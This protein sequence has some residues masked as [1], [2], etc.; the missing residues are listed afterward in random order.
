VNSVDSG[1]NLAEVVWCDHVS[2]HGQWFSDQKVPAVSIYQ[3]RGKKIWLVVEG[4]KVKV[5]CETCFMIA[6]QRPLPT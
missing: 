4:G 3:P 1:E 6:V 2:A 5:M